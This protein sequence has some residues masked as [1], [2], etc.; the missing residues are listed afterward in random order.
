MEA[1]EAPSCSYAP[2]FQDKYDSK[3]DQAKCVSPACAS[4]ASAASSGSK[5]PVWG[6]TSCDVTTTDQV[7]GT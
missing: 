3:G 7:S 6:R 5:F 4:K 1:Y 2:T